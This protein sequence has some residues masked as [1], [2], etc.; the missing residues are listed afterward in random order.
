M[1]ENGMRPSHPGAILTGMIEGL[2]EETGKDYPVAEIASGLGVS[3]ETL[4]S[5]LNQKSAIDAEMAV[6]L[7][8]AF[9]TSADLW[10]NL[11]RN[12]DLWEAENKVNRHEIKYFVVNDGETGLLSA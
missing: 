5:L 9:N 2:R 12:Y 7:S 3:D 4:S 11:Q 8:E 1:K 6:K 10:L